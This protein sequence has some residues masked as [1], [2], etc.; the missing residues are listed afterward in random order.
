M[1]GAVDFLLRARF[2]GDWSVI[3]HSNPWN[4]L[5]DDPERR[6]SDAR[7]MGGPDRLER[8]RTKGPVTDSTPGP[9]STTCWT[10]G[11]FPG[12]SALWS[13]PGEPLA[14][15]HR[16]TGCHRFRHRRRKTRHGGRRGLHRAGWVHRAGETPSVIGSPNWPNGT[17]STGHVV[18]GGG[19]PAIGNRRCRNPGGGPDRPDSAGSASGRVPWWRPFSGRRRA[20]VPWGFR[21]RTTRL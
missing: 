11:R 9:G 4:P 19:T 21:C 2:G 20:P 12:G 3:A 8:H 13:V 1:L 15:R 6:R 7:A 17:D 16:P 5:L 18:G 14:V 10:P